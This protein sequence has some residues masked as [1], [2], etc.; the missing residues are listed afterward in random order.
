MLN[1]VLSPHHPASA[2]IPAGQIA[3]QRGRQSL[4]VLLSTPHIWWFSVWMMAVGMKLRR[5]HLPP[6]TPPMAA[7]I[8]MLM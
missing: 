6:V 8:P 3:A 5:R 7:E 2:V 1:M 4:P